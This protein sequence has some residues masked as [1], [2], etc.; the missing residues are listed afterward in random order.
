MSVDCLAILQARVSS[1][2]LPGKVL[3]PILGRPMLLR[4][5]ERLQR[6]REFDRLVVA[7]STNASDTPLAVAC[8]DWGVDC[9][10]GNLD[11]VLDRFVD[12]AR[13]YQPKTVVRLT[14]D[15][16]LA[17]PEVIDGAI[18]HFRQGGYDYVSNVTPPTFPDGLDVEVM[19]Y[20]CLEAAHREAGLP[21]EREH[22][23]PFIRANGSR[24]RIGCYDNDRDL[25]HL[26]W[27]VDEAADF[28]FVNA[29][30]EALYPGN[31]AFTTAD[32]LAL[33]DSREG[34]ASLNSGIERNEGLIKSLRKDAV[35]KDAPQ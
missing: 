16:P 22:V 35:L 25:S 8:R 26:R 21:S 9:H 31:P 23:T 6:C 1:T 18:K 34:L 12:A 19:R 7:T 24:F 11:D 30:Y 14:G 28:R 5:I 27:T 4:Q 10:R 3:M 17:D 2:R 33:L 15:C 29:V 32:I 13:R 20:S